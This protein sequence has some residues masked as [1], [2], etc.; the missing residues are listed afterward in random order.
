MTPQMD[1]ARFHAD[2]DRHPD[3]RIHL[4][5][6]VADF[7]EPA[8]VLYPGSYVDIAP[9]VYFDDVHYMDLDRRAAKF[10][11]QAAD[12][13]RLIEEKRRRAGR[14]GADFDVRF[15]HGDYQAPLDIADR[16]V[17]LLISLYAG[18]ISESCTRYLA[19]GGHLLVND[20][21]GD[22]SMA[23]LDRG[24]EL[25]AVVT[26]RDGRYRVT[27]ENLD[28]Y[29]VPKRGEPPTVDGLHESGRGVAYSRSPTAYLFRRVEVG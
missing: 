4:F 2:Y 10:F 6:A 22:A 27:T 15:D 17:E 12:V 18:F 5:A 1:V 21:H 7:I 26:S 8:T 19:P 24:Y 23:S 14:G 29:L 11:G 25:A 16:S 13:R 9:S 20:S 28:G 3:D